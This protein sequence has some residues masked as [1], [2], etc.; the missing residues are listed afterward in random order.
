MTLL[1]VSDLR[2]TFDTDRGTVTALDGVDFEISRGETVCLVGESGSG[3]TVAC[4]SLTRLV[5]TPPGELRGEI[6]FDGADVLE[7]SDAELRSLRGDRIAHVFQ[8]PQ[9]A[10]DPVYTV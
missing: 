10:L 2:V 5:P 8:N 1:S 9:S 4:E 7:M 3:K 6:R